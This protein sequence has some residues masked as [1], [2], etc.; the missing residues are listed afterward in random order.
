MA[1]H[2]SM[3]GRRLRNEAKA[4]EADVVVAP[5]PLDAGIEDV[6]AEPV[7]LWPVSSNSIGTFLKHT[8]APPDE[9]R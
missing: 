5:K 3:G 2:G 1:T 6:T 4:D 8:A 9:R 7:E